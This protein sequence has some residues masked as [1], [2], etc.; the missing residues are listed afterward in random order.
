[1][2]WC[3]DLC[4]CVDVLM[5]WWLCWCIDVLSSCV[6]VLITVYVSTRRQNRSSIFWGPEK[7]IEVPMIASNFTWIFLQEKFRKVFPGKR[8]IFCHRGSFRG[9]LIFRSLVRKCMFYWRKKMINPTKK[10]VEVLGWLFLSPKGK[11]RSFFPPE[12]ENRSFFLGNRI[13]VLKN[14]K[15]TEKLTKSRTLKCDTR[16]DFSTKFGI[17]LGKISACTVLHTDNNTHVGICHFSRL[18]NGTSIVPF[19]SRC[20][21]MLNVLM[22]W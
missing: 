2:C 16:F 15:K 6:D 21:D 14:L 20:V 11:N 8:W 17:F 1:M 12:K 5:C 7:K 4:W 22:C 13:N 3:D 9:T 10:K 19:M 18:K